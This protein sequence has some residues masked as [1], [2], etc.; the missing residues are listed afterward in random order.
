MK[1]IKNSFYKALSLIFVIL[2]TAHHL[3]GQSLLGGSLQ[4]AKNATL[5]DVNIYH[6]G[7]TISTQKHA[8]SIPKITYEI[9][10]NNDQAV[11]YVFICSSAPKYSLKQFPNQEEQ[12]NTIEYLKI[13]PKI[14][15]LFYKLELIHDENKA[16]ASYH[17]EITETPLPE[18]GQ[19]PDT[20]LIITYFPS[21]IKAIKGGNQLELPT[22]FIDNSTID[23]F[24]SEENFEEALVRLQLSSLDL[25]AFHA[26][27]KRKVKAD[28]RR[29]LIMDTLV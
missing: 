27:T 18:T 5:D 11:F 21:F 26:P 19:I 3:Y 23:I 7:K 20:A 15:H 10:K 14:P 29:L 17:W 24:G 6:C 1:K 25:N 2:S 16:Q 4:F 22:I 8:I 28:N 12:Q 13:D 9:P